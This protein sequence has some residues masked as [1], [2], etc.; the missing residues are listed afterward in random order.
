MCHCPS[1]HR[2]D[3]GIQ[4]L[5]FPL[6]HVLAEG[7]P[8]GPHHPLTESRNGEPC[9]VADTSPVIFKDFSSEFCFRNNCIFILFFS[10]CYFL[11]SNSR[12]ELTCPPLI[13]HSGAD[14]FGY[15]KDLYGATVYIQSL[16]FWPGFMRR[17]T[18]Q[19]AAVRSVTAIHFLFIGK[20]KI[21]KYWVTKRTK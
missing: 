8:W 1:G 19:R 10:T 9:V 2:S 12:R 5:S 21:P 16:L 14:L 15:Q 4:M 3:P 13:I 18:E 20:L 6:S 7:W 17:A 11:P